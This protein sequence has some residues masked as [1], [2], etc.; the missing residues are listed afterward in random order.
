MNIKNLQKAIENQDQ[1][2]VDNIF[3]KLFPKG[4]EH[5]FQKINKQL[6]FFTIDNHA[7]ENNIIEQELKKQHFMIFDYFALQEQL[8][9]LTSN[10]LLVSCDL[11]Y[12]KHLK[13]NN[14]ESTPN[15]IELLNDLM[16]KLFYQESFDCL[17]YLKNTI[18]FKLNEPKSST[19]SFHYMTPNF[20][21]IYYLGDTETT[22]LPT[23]DL[24][25]NYTEKKEQYLIQNNIPTPTSEEAIK[26]QNIYL[27]FIN[28]TENSNNIHESIQQEILSKIN[29]YIL[30]KQLEE[31]V[32]NM[33]TN[34]TK[35]KL[36][37]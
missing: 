25:M 12:I 10:T 24:I 14:F 17:D 33:A 34:L 13:L 22:F 26:L 19:F 15:N 2:S 5:I 8:L 4:R 28:N 27:K 29:Q 20:Y 6:A 35:R 7:I 11:D 21:D 32:D 1:A 31:N 9:F 23:Y 30:N 3:L 18:G 36:K 16:T 37:L